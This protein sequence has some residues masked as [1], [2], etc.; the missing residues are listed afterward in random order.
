M[1]RTLSELPFQEQAVLWGHTYEIL[2][3][4]GVIACLIERKILSANHPQLSTWKSFRLLDIHK[5]L[6]RQLE[7]LDENAIAVLDA[8]IEHLALT[9]FGVGRTP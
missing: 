5:H 7:L 6:S 8:A 9:A 3:K 1:K 4:R 2:V